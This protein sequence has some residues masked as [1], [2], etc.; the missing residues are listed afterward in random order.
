MKVEIT[1]LNLFVMKKS[2]L[3]LSRHIA[4][5]GMAL[6]AACVEVPPFI[7]YSEPIVLLKDTT[8]ITGTLPT[9]EDK[10]ALIED[11]SGVRCTNCPDANVTAK[12]I[13]SK[14]P[15][16]V[17]VVTLFP[18]SLKTFTTPYPGEDTLVTQDAEYIMTSIMSTPTGLPN[19]AVDRKKFDGEPAITIRETKWEKYVNDQ[20]LLKS[21]VNTDLDVIAKPDE[22]KL[23]ANIKATFTKKFDHPVFLTLM[24]LESDIE[25]KQ[26][27][28][29]GEKDDYIH[30]HVLRKCITPFNGVELAPNVEIGRVF[31]KGFEIKVPEKYNFA[32][33]SVVVLINLNQSDNKEVLQSKE[34]KP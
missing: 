1:V 34:D 26:D 10:V 2:F 25:S 15:G 33:C 17:V 24:L 13:Q 6:L 14:N 20:L 28:R 23:I 30:H 4:M 22:R 27:T 32:N 3:K 12:D 9:P 19:G 11:L 8:Y 5:V 31:E 21:A 29:T 18:S 16:K 7:D